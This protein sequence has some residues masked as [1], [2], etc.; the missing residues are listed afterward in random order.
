MAADSEKLAVAK[1]RLTLYYK[2]E[3]AILSGQSYEIEGLKLTRADLGKVQDMIAALENRVER[4][5]ASPRPRRRIIIP[6]D[7]W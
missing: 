2:A 7:G 1:A 4:L 6:K 5:S 3:K